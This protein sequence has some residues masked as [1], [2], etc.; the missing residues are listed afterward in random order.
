[1]PSHLIEDDAVNW[2]EQRPIEQ[3]RNPAWTKS[4][5]LLQGALVD[6]VTQPRISGKPAVAAQHNLSFFNLGDTP[7]IDQRAGDQ[8]HG[9]LW[10]KFFTHE[11]PEE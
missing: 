5:N 7:P 4:R 3:T 11:A 9:T 8:R 2:S 1:M 10:A 6:A